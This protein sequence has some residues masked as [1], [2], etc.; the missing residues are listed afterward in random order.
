MSID[1][2]SLTVSLASLVVSASVAWLT[3]WK[4]GRVRLV[5]PS[6]FAFTNRGD[7]GPKIFFRGLLYSTARRG[8][9]LESLFVRLRRGEARQ[10]FT[11]WACGEHGKLVRG[12]RLYVGHEGVALDHHFLLPQDG[13]RFEFLAGQYEL[14]VCGTFLDHA[15]PAVLSRTSLQLSPEQAKALEDP[16]RSVYFNWWPDSARYESH[17]RA[18]PPRELP[19]GTIGLLREKL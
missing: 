4:P 17:V 13:G 2:I 16:Q 1:P 19:E 7:D 11:F 12:C 14:E 5:K 15:A 8:I 3:L 10:N 6:L 18:G 9:T